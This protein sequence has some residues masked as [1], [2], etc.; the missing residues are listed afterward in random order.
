MANNAHRHLSFLQEKTPPADLSRFKKL[1]ESPRPGD[2][3]TANAIGVF[4]TQVGSMMARPSNRHGSR[5]GSRL[6]S[7]GSAKT[8][9]P[10]MKREPLFAE[11]AL[12]RQF[13]YADK[14]FD[15]KSLPYEKKLPG[16]EEQPKKAKVHI[17]FLALFALKLR[18]RGPKRDPIRNKGLKW[19]QCKSCVSSRSRQ[20]SNALK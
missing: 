12:H 18:S 6:G 15:N 20:S 4:Q 2:G 19:V 7:R 3:S 17:M 10:A 1:T 5:Q 11:K 14:N 16:N 13:L 8:L 9:N